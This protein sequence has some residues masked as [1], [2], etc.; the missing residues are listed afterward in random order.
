MPDI[1]P[2]TEWTHFSANVAAVVPEEWDGTVEQFRIDFGSGE[3]KTVRVRDIRLRPMNAAEVQAEAE[4]RAAKERVMAE[5]SRRV[6][7]AL[8]S[9]ARIET[10]GNVLA[11]THALGDTHI[12]V[13]GKDLDLASQ[14]WEH[15]DAL[16]PAAH[17]P[18]RLVVGEGP[19]P[20]NH[21]VVRLLN[22][23]HICQ[24]QFL[25]YPPEVTG[26]VQVC[27]GE[28]GGTKTI[29]TAPF[30]AGSVHELRLF[31]SNGN[32]TGSLRIADDI[33][34][35]FAIAVGDFADAA[36]DEIA[37]APLHVAGDALPVLILSA[38]GGSWRDLRSTSRRG[39]MANFRSRPRARRVEREGNCYW[40]TSAGGLT[41]TCCIRAR[42]LRRR[43]RPDWAPTV[44]ECM[45]RRTGAMW[46]R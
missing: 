34:A 2:T 10:A 20:E 8:V 22:R 46:P 9:P 25:A 5:L 44:P 35:P 24:V 11:A 18:P 17:L 23:H 4:A 26:G 40:L 43:C 21:T 30:A 3:G 15:A 27:A 13:V 29:V 31:D 36:G 38:P 45:Q 7:A 16:D 33:P 42:G 19:D 1:S 32:R 39:R 14:L 28:I 12:A 37:V 6:E 41:T